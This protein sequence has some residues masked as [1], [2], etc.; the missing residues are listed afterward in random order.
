MNTQR[1]IIIKQ[2][3]RKVLPHCRLGIIQAN[4][5]NRQTPGAIT[6]KMEKAINY[7]KN[8]NFEDIRSHPVMKDFRRAYKALGADPNRYR[9]A[10]DSL[11]RRM[12]KQKELNSINMYVDLINLLSMET[13]YSIGG[14]DADKIN[15]TIHLTKAPEGIL[16]EGIGRG[17]LNIKNLPA[18]YDNYAYFGSPTSDSIK[19]KID[20]STQ[21][22]LIVYYDFYRNDRLVNAIELTKQYLQKYCKVE[23]ID[24]SIIE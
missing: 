11:L 22:I 3:I 13:V 5:P 1:D 24:S 16:Y 10:A 4:G 20:Y 6:Q 21:N 17:E 8:K 2:S 7:W 19:T 23:A 9:P 15:G 18:L 14:F 12:I